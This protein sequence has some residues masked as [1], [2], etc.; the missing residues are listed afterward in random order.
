[1]KNYYAEII[2]VGNEVLAGQTVNTNAAFISR[3]LMDIGLQVFW[4]TTIR[5]THDEI[6]FSLKTASKRADIVLVTGGLG[7]TP[8]DITKN[9]I[10][11]YFNTRLVTNSSVLGDVDKFVKSRGFQLTD[12]NR[13]Q[14][15]VP[16]SAKIIRNPIGTAPGLLLEKNNIP[17]FFLPGVPREMKYLLTESILEI[18]SSKYDLPKIYTKLLRTTSI[19]EAKL[20]EKLEAV[21]KKY[22]KFELGFYPRYFGVDIRFRHQTKNPDEL[23]DFENY[24]EKV[25]KVVAKY[26]YSSRPI[27]LEEKL[28][29]LLKS[30]QLTLSTAESFTGGLIGDMITNVPGSSEYYTGGAITYSNESKIELLNV[31]NSTLLEHGAVSEP[32]A[33]E[34]VH[35]VGNLFKSN[36]AIATTG[37]AG[38]GG[39]TP[40]KPVGLC[41]IAVRLNKKEVVK[42]F[43][44]G[45]ER[46]INKL[47]GA[48]AGME[49]LRRTLLDI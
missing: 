6:I 21:V 33:L 18:L 30:R 23:I 47:R 17:Y 19:P 16:E 3:Q 35:G 46:R 15:L 43:N 11:E 29:E 48:V 34:M 40:N 45:T 26:I 10:C 9:S 13:D 22:S 25:K 49:M 8:D 24:Y 44:F 32:V 5:D 12:L 39:A 31:H 2:S 41:F 4:V 14:A 36:C 28:G 7:P 20:Y 37:I 1:M 38:P 27:E 42:N